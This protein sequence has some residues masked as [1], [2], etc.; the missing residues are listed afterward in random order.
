VLFPRIPSICVLR[1][2]SRLE[3][4]ESN[5]LGFRPFGQGAGDEL[6]A[7][8]QANRQWRT[9][10]LHQFVQ[11]LDNPS[12][13]QAG[14]DLDAQPFEVEFVDDVEDPEPPVGSRR[15]RDVQPWLGWPAACRGCLMRAGSRFLPRRGRF[16]RSSQCMRQSTVLPQGLPS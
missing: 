13:R 5:A 7:V 15:I 9:T 12:S 8:V 4:I 6:G 3:A 11:G 14:I 16:S 10:R 1:R 2:L